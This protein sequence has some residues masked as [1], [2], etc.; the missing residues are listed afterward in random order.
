MHLKYLHRIS[1][2]E[3]TQLFL[4]TK[5]RT[6]TL[7][8]L[9]IEWNISVTF[10][11]GVQIFFKKSGSYLKILGPRRVTRNEFHAEDPQ[12]LGATVK[13]L[14]AGATWFSGF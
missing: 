7:Y 8:L 5:L 6:I 11:T 9:L 1:Q 4:M 12:I 10:L 13:Y 3:N 2:F 14:V